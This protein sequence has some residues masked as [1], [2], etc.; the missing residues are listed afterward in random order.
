MTYMK[1]TLRQPK[2]ETLKNKGDFFL[3]MDIKIYFSSN[4]IQINNRVGFSLYFPILANYYFLSFYS[5]LTGSNYGKNISF[6]YL[7]LVLYQ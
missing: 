7:Q 5:Y 4:S 6:H 1:N 2:L 3:I